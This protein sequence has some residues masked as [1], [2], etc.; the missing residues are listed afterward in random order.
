MM[1]KRKAASA[2]MKRAFADALCPVC[3]HGYVRG[4]PGEARLHAA[5]HA[6]HMG[7]RK[8]RREPRLAALGGDVRVD[9]NSPKWLQRI[10]HRHRQ[11]VGGRCVRAEMGSPD[12]AS[13]SGP[14]WLSVPQPNAAAKDRGL[15]RS[16]SPVPLLFLLGI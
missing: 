8:P 12:W 10:A 16:R 15:F 14:L 9:A 5:F 6:R 2:R 3:K 13:Q 7:Q 4:L 11:Q 1:G